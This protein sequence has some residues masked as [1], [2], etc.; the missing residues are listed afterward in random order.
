MK[1]T[2]KLRTL[3]L[4]PNFV[5]CSLLTISYTSQA[6]TTFNLITS[7][8]NGTSGTPISFLTG[9]ASGNIPDNGAP[10]TINVPAGVVFTIDHTGFDLTTITGDITINVLGT[11]PATA[12][13][14]IF[15]KAHAK[16]Y[17][18]TGDFLFISSSNTDGLQELNSF[19]QDRVFTASA[20]YK[21]TDFPTII[22]AGGVQG[23]GFLPVELTE[24]RV[25]LL[26]GEVLLE[27]ATAS[28]TGNEAFLIEHSFDGRNFEAIG[29]IA[30]NGTTQ[31][32]NEYRF[33]HPKASPGIH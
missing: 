19:G 30:G 13:Q 22:S 28:E 17:F 29:E 3:R 8:F 16:I 18:N 14:I 27:W 26:G 32:A 25:S 20:T 24:F 2:F 12:G 15:N 10:Y 4:L 1:L 33:I 21:G 6:A 7:T 11:D 5:F 23:S 31:A 9:P